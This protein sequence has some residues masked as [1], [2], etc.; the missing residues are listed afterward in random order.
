MINRQRKTKKMKKQEEIEK[1]REELRKEYLS[2]EI[3]MSKINKEKE[4]LKKRERS[5]R[6]AL[7]E[8]VALRSENKA[9]K[10]KN[11]ALREFVF[12]LGKELRE[13]LGEL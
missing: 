12:S 6:I 4:D 9:L 13:D 8:N 2:L 11:N 5:V 1:Y 7:A 3:M 10:E